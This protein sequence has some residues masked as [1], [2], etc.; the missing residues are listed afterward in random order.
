M[1]IELNT[2]Y[3]AS[4]PIPRSDQGVLN[5]VDQDDPDGSPVDAS[6]ADASQQMPTRPLQT[7]VRNYIFGHSLIVHT[8]PQFPTPS[9]ETTVPHW[10]TLER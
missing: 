9:D 10:L 4:A 5:T 2:T 6:Q 7:N 8:P 3:D 1:D